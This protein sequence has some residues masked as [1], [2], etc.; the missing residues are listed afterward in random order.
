MRADRVGAVFDDADAKWFASIGMN[1]LRLAINY[2]HLNDDMNPE[3]MKESGFKLIDR[4]IDIVGLGDR[5]SG[6]LT[7]MQNARHGI[8]TIIDLHA[9]PGGQNFD[10][11]SDN[12]LPEALLF[13]F[14]EFQDRTVR[15]W[16]AIAERYKG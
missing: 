12:N 2:R 1:L 14:K 13:E 4:V 16:E 7:C 15:I 9:A 10:W 5:L 6:Q 3:E 11:H 8:Y